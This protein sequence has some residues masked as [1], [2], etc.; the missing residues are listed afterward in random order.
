MNTPT[1]SKFE[2]LEGVLVQ[3]TPDM[4]CIRATWLDG[5]GTPLKTRGGSLEAME[6]VCMF[7]DGRPEGEWL[8]ADEFE[9]RMGEDAGPLPERPWD[10]M[11]GN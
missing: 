1:K 11:R 2:I 5:T 3:W 9:R 8:P 10:Q 7:C 4:A 6:E